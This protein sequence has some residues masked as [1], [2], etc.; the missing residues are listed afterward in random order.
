ML[1]EE[2]IPGIELIDPIML[3]GPE[4]LPLNGFWD[5]WDDGLPWLNGE[6]PMPN[7]GLWLEENGDLPI[8]DCIWLG[9]DPNGFLD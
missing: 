1:K 8:W 3:E 2:P 6:L 4:L 5:I 7:I 9:L